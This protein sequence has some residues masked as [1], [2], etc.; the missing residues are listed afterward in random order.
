[1][2]SKLLISMMGAVVCVCVAS[3]LPDALA[4]RNPVGPPTVPPSSL[5]GATTANP[6]YKSYTS[7]VGGYGNLVI[8]GN[9]T[10]G[11]YF[12]GIVPYRSVSEFTA[13]L[14]SSSLNSFLRDSAGA[15]LF[16]QSPGTPQPYYLPS[17]TVTAVR[18]GSVS[19]LEGPSIRLNKGTGQFVSPPALTQET[20]KI[21]TQFPTEPIYRKFRPVSGFPEELEDLLSRQYRIE[22][23]EDVER[24][25]AEQQLAELREELAEVKRRAQEIDGKV[26][27]VWFKS[28]EPTQAEDSYI[29]KPPE[30][31]V[32]VPQEEKQ[33][34][35][36]VSKE[37]LQKA[38]E[39]F[40]KL[41]EKIKQEEKPDEDEA[42]PA[43]QPPRQPDY[44]RVS[45]VNKVDV[46]VLRTPFGTAM[47]GL[48]ASFTSAKEQEFNEYLKTAQDYMQK[49]RYYRA[50]D[51]YTMASVL[52]PKTP[53]PYAGK[54]HALLAAGEYVSSAFFLA[55]AIETFPGYTSRVPEA[56]K[57]RWAAGFKINLV[58]MIGDRDK[59]EERV[60]DLV[61]WQKKTG[62]AEL[63]FLLGYVFYNTDRLY[64]A[65][66]V[67]DAASE[68][69]SDA[70]A[71]KVLKQVIDKAVKESESMEWR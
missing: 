48:K 63:R 26:S 52:K 4:V 67:I 31:Q 17:Q 32:Q 42:K 23:R 69:M 45:D 47:L 59:L 20:E 13:P 14:G 10:G 21:Q 37:M 56:I 43:G 24:S 35:P 39:D 61:K 34:P 36:D 44:S 50:A 51:A 58:E 22:R 57:G 3:F 71:V 12:R 33:K 68:K 38:E 2:K 70:K 15:H 1:M 55:K 25:V 54:S 49:G 60:R 9:V 62:S 46:P 18:R 27:D 65:K 11:K 6:R 5:G 30:Q 53:L 40:E 7:P 19:G 64:L 16:R 29:I 8:T 28:P 41:L 66:Q